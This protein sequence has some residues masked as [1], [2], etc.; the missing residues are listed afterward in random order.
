MFGLTIPPFRPLQRLVS[1]ASKPI[2]SY[3]DATP[4]SNHQKQ[5]QQQQQRSHD[6]SQGPGLEMIDRPTEQQKPSYS[7]IPI[8]APGADKEKLRRKT[9]G[10]KK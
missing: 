1:A 6:R 7:P 5:Q 9:K 4:G 8:N 3:K 2:S 10:K